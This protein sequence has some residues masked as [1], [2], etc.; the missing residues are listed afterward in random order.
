MRNQDTFY[1]SN[2]AFSGPSAGMGDALKAALDSLG[3]C[4]QA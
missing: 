2:Q 3:R 1:N 4:I